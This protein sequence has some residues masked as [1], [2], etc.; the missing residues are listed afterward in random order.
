MPGIVAGALVAHPPV[1]VPEVGGARAAEVNAT[2]SAMERLDQILSR[3]PAELV[4]VISPHSASSPDSIPVRR[5]ARVAGDLGRFGAPQVRVVADVDVDAAEKLLAS[6]GA[7]GFSLSWSDDATLD[8]GIVVPLYLL[9]RTRA[10]RR[11]IFMGI[12]G[13][14][15]DRF[16]EFGAFLHRELGS[17]EA[18][19]IASGDLSHR[20][21]PEAPYGF[22]P[23]GEV[24]DKR[25]I[26]AL[27]TQQWD[28]IERLD[29]LL[30]EEAGECGLRPLSLLIGAARAAG[31]RSEVFSYEGPFG[32]G[33][34]VAHFGVGH[35]P[36]EVQAIGRKAIETYLRERRVIE[37]PA[38]IP[39]NLEQPS[40]AFVTLRKNGELRG[41]M[42]SLV[43]TESSA[44][45]EIIRFA[46]ASAIRDPRFEPVDLDEVGQLTVSAQL[47]D[48]PEPVASMA[49]LDPAVYGVIARSGDR[50]ALLL[51]GIEGIDT[52]AEQI[53][54]VCEKAGIDR[55]GPLRLERFR[56]RTIS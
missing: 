48:P 50:Q 40:A 6:A 33:Y 3:N 32:V 35:Q 37:P 8:H 51:P 22:R 7:Q 1:L 16:R 31:L 52:V 11:F 15:L 47:L 45:R 53:A 55:L 10:T 23:E 24:M 4:I 29:P 46:I 44:A 25:V 5:S 2:H 21:T 36:G 43:P 49:D 27:R 56:T 12:S 41:C 14:P 39:S 9:P 18:I 17:R 30:V 26:E 54:A 19:L 38:P 13:W 42:G 20:L 28:Q 34:P